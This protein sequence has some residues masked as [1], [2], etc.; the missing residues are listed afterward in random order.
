MT[1]ESIGL[2]RNIIKISPN[3]VTALWLCAV[4]ILTSA[5]FV[6]MWTGYIL[7]GGFTEM[8]YWFAFFTDLFICGMIG[9][10]TIVIQENAQDIKIKIIR[11]G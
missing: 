8:T 9:W 3:R 1:E 7:F 5:T 10:F 6:G 4:L 2:R 11:E